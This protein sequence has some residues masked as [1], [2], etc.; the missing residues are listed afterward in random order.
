[1]SRLLGAGEFDTAAEAA[2]DGRITEE[3]YGFLVRLVAAARVT[4]TLPPAPT[5]SGRWDE[6]DVVTETVH[7]WCAEVLFDGGLLQAFD[8]CR[9][10]RELA[11]YLERALRNWLISRSRAAHGPRL[12]A[13]SAEL[14]DDEAEFCRLRNAHVITERWWGLAAWPYADLYAGR[15]EAVIAAAWALGDWPLVR[16]TGTERNE[17]VLSTPE[18]RKYLRGLLDA[19]AT[20]LSGRHLDTT[21]RHR[22][23]YAYAYGPHAAFDDEAAPS[24]G[25]GPADGLLLQEAARDALAN[26]TGRQVVVL[27]RR[28]DTT[29]EALAADLGVSRGTVDNEYRR[30]VAT[31][32]GA[33]PSA[34]MFDAVLETVR[35][36]ASRQETS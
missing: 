13:R 16:Y 3:L 9:A 23:A 14:M 21:F 10:P 36:L 1:M 34:S 19:I 35:D 30:A 15:D 11:R 2:R 17:P 5:P 8:A 20:G 25:P 18:L 26:M 32:D 4:R 27:L 12:L 22:F 7:A 24:A 6:P 33:A 31:I 29:L 28:P